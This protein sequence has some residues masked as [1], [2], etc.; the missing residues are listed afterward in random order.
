MWIQASLNNTGIVKLS[1]AWKTGCVFVQLV[2]INQFP[3]ILSTA[4]LAKSNLKIANEIQETSHENSEDM[5]RFFPPLGFVPSCLLRLLFWDGYSA[6]FGSLP[7]EK[8][9]E[10]YKTYCLPCHGI[11]GT[12]DG[13][14]SKVLTPPPAD[15]TSKKTRGKADEKLL[16][17]IENGKPKTAMPPWKG[18][19]SEQ[20]RRDVL[21]YIRTLVN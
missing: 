17:I 13:P 5:S 10:T 11:H 7:L 4:L 21:G 2:I 1:K 3:C 15:F 19:L 16:A 6:G 8:G 14:A 9:K 12:G 18:T 20:Q